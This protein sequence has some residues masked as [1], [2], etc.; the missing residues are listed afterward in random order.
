MWEN[1]CNLTN[2]WA[3]N[4]NLFKDFSSSSIALNINVFANFTQA[5][6]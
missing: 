3:K 4:N 5:Y 1:I 6:L 2:L